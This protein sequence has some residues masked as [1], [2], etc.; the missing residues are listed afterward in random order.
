MPLVKN[1]LKSGERMVI[2]S[3]SGK[4]STTIFRPIKVGD[5]MSLVEAELKTGR[6]HQIRVHAAKIAYPIAGD[7]KYGDPDFNQ[8]MKKHGLKRMFLHASKLDFY[9]EDGVRASFKAE[10][11]N[12]LKMVLT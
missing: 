7:T 9:W 10:I 4:E 2:V 12:D 6:T 11:G 8:E 3:E 5:K 1:N